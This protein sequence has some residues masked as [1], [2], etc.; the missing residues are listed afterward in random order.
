MSLA[1]FMNVS[2]APMRRAAMAAPAMSYAAAVPK[3][4]VHI[5]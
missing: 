2:R 3:A 1:R 4:A 5:F